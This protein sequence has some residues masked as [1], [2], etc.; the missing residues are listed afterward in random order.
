MEEVGFLLHNYASSAMSLV[1]HTRNLNKRLYKSSPQALSEIQSEIDKRFLGSQT[2]QII[3]GLRD[4]T[5]HRNLP[6]VGKVTTF[7]AWDN[8]PTLEAAYYLSTESL[9]EWDGWKPLARQALETMK[10][11][12]PETRIMEHKSSNIAVNRLVT[13]HHNQV[14]EFYDWLR[15]KRRERL[16]NTFTNRGRATGRGE[17]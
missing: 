6:I 3:Q 16:A 4:Y 12:P 9:L 15:K 1:N 2:H 5:Q 17:T 11:L 8:K 13:D 10:N 7:S 14:A